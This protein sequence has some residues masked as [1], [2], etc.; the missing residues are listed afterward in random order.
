MTAWTALT[1][2]VIVVVGT[3]TT[4]AIWLGILGWL[5]AF[6]MVRCTN[7]RHLTMSTAKEPRE[8][9]PQCRHPLL[10]HPVYAVRHPG[11]RVRV[12]NDPL[13]Y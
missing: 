4:V 10:T 8:S 2:F 12:R 5:G 11:A 13:R 1:V 7:C 3:F 9:C 6:H